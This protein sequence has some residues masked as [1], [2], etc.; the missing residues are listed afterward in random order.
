MT[1]PSG[2]PVEV[3]ALRSTSVTY[4]LSRP[5]KHEASLVAAPDNKSSRPVANGSSVPAWPVRAPVRC[6]TP[7]TIANE[8]GPAGLSTRI[9][10]LGLRPRGGTR[11]EL[12]LDE[13]GD[14]LDRIVAREARCL[15]VTAAP[16]LARDRGNIELVVA[17][18]QAD[19]ARPVPRLTDQ[20]GHVRALDHPQVVNDPLRVRLGG[21]DVR[22]VAPQQ[23]RDDQPAAVVNF[24]PLERAG[25]QLQL[26]E[27]HRLVHAAEDGVDIR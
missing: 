20:S 17:R 27:L 25:E 10:P 7:A 19:A 4:R 11:E 18:A 21:T 6:R 9:R 14:L 12:A 5:T 24:R 23:V 1:S 16:R 2:S 15:A 26:R 3:R 22:E 8:D 13:I